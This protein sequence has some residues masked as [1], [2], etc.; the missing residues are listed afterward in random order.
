MREIRKRGKEDIFIMELSLNTHTHTHKHTHTAE[1]SLTEAHGVLVVAVQC[2]ELRYQLR[3]I[4]TTIVSNDGRQL[5]EKANI[6]SPPFTCMS[7][8]QDTVVTAIY[9]M[10]CT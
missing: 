8:I 9:T 6:H 5:R 10:S 7:T 3:A 4:I 1:A 2:P